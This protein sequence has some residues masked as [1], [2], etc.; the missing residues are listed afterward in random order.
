MN[1]FCRD[2]EQL[3]KGIGNANRYLI[4]EILMKGPRTVGEIVTLVGLSQPNVSQALKVL[5][6]AKL[7]EDSRN[8]Q[9]IYYSIN[10]EHLANLLKQLS[11]QV[12]RCPVTPT[13]KSLRKSAQKSLRKTPPKTT[14]KAKTGKMK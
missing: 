4:L 11:M 9:E 3:G 12:D 10:A 13:Q 7:V 1:D 2:V 8:G 6:S 14:Q 5:K